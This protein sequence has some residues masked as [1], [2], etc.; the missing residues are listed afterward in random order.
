MLSIADEI[1]SIQATLLRALASPHRLRIV[2]RLGCGPLDVT[3]LAHALG[4]SQT[5]TSQHLAAMRSVGIVEAHRDGRSVRYG[6]TDPGILAAC[7][8]MREVLVRRLSRLG[9]L[10]AA[11]GDAAPLGDPPATG[12]EPLVF[13]V[14]ASKVGPT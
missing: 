10:A 4:M 3:E 7:G 12:D 14:P 1:D 5:A 8:L 13:V 2:H 11:A 6:L 9:D